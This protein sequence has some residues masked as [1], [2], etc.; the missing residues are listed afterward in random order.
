MTDVDGMTLLPLLPVPPPR[1]YRPLLF[2]LLHQ[3]CVPHLKVVSG[4][5]GSSFLFTLTMNTIATTPKTSPSRK[6]VAFYFLRLPSSRGFLFCPFP[7]P[8]SKEDMSFLDREG[9]E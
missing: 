5:L 7:Q 1:H 4:N 3:F 2:P 9:K 6:P 8:A